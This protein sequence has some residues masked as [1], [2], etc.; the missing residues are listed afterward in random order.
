MLRKKLVAQILVRD[1][2]IADE[3]SFPGLPVKIH[4]Q[5]FCNLFSKIP[6]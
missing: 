4:M 1:L 5:G 3:F 6:S 2:R